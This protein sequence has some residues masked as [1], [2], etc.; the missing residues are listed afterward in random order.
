ME[1]LFM[2]LEKRETGSERLTRERKAKNV[3]LKCPVDKECLEFALT[4]ASASKYLAGVWAGKNIE[5]LRDLYEEL[6]HNL[7]GI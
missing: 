5:E 7:H 3:C 4:F 6:K 2:P 1:D